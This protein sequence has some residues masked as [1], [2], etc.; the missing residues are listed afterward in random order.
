MTLKSRISA[1]LICYLISSLIV[2]STNYYISGAGDDSFNGTSKNTPWKTI[3]KLNSSWSLMAPGDSVLFRRGDTFRGMIQPGLSGTLSL[4]CV[5]SAYGSGEN[6]VISG[7]KLVTSWSV[8]SGNIWKATLTGFSADPI[9][10]IY[11]NKLLLE[12]AREPNNN[13]YNTTSN[14]TTT[15]LNSTELNQANDYWTGATLVHRVRNWVWD[16][17]VVQSSTNG[18]L[19]IPSSAALLFTTQSGRGFYFINKLSFL[20]AANEWYYDPTNKIM[21]TWFPDNANPTGLTVEVPVKDYRYGIL[22]N[23]MNNWTVENLTFTQGAWGGIRANSTNNITIRNCVFDKN[24][25]VGIVINVGE[26]V[27]IQN[28]TIRNTINSG[29]RANSLKYY[30]ISNNKISNCGLPTSYI[31]GYDRWGISVNPGVK[32]KI[33]YNTIDTVGSSGIALTDSLSVIEKNVIRNSCYKISDNGGIYLVEAGKSVTTTRIYGD[34]IRNNFISDTYGNYDAANRS[35]WVQGMDISDYSGNCVIENNTVYNNEEYGLKLFGAFNIKIRNNVLFANGEAQIGIGTKSS[36]F[37]ESVVKNNLITDNLLACNNHLQIPFKIYSDYDT[38]NFGTYDNNLYYNPYG[39]YTV[40]LSWGSAGIQ[41]AG[42]FLSRWKVL[43]PSQNANSTEISPFLSAYKVNNVIG[44]NKITNGNFNSTIVGWSQLLGSSWIGTGGIDGGTYQIGN[45]TTGMLTNYSNSFTVETGKTYRL[46]F[47]CK[48]SRPAKVSTKICQQYF[49]TAY[50]DERFFE[51]KTTVENYEHVFKAT[52]DASD[53]SVIF[54]T[55]DDDIQFTYYLDNI[56]LVEVEASEIDSNDQIRLYTNPSDNV[57][58]IN[59]LNEKLT[60]IYTNQ[61]LNSFELQPWTSRVVLIEKLPLA[62]QNMIIS[63]STIRVFPIP[64]KNFLYIE[65]GM[66]DKIRYE[67]CNTSAKI[68][69]SGFVL[70]QYQSLNIEMLPQGIY[71]I[72]FYSKSGYCLNTQ[73]L[74]KL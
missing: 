21:Y 56:E 53:A 16:K 65:T 58:T 13:F 30:E 7:S 18:Q 72:K 2:F 67:I 6:P 74:V 51:L 71:F 66:L 29:I 33:K 4:P 8:Y 61:A 39:K 15:T 57:I 40:D 11:A 54:L 10:S 46:K 41:Y 68:L 27:K 3:G 60:D 20:D 44:Q 49:G 5:I 37:A 35:T 32:G 9:E 31:D 64:S 24:S 25:G 28:N 73:K 38:Y 42:S 36:L 48:A 17:V 52:K 1:L 14:G 12:P 63:D 23:F 69:M 22:F 34:T 26:N 19:V 62:T 47:S 45:S 55:T 43:Q 59:S 50:S 70:N